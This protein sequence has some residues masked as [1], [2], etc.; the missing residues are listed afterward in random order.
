MQLFCFLKNFIFCL[1][2]TLQWIKHENIF[3]QMDPTPFKES[4]GKYRIIVLVL[5]A[6]Y[7]V[8]SSY[9]INSGL[10]FLT[11]KYKKIKRHFAISISYHPE[12]TEGRLS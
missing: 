9:M 8:G 7:F 12:G 10:F 1:K 2:C 6:E 11:F 5:K 3:P 4:D